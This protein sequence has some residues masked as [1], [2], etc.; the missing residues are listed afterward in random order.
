MADAVLVTGAFGLVGSATVKRLAADGRRVVATDLDIP[1]NRKAADK[2]PAGRRGALRRPHRPR[3]GRRADGRRRT[4]RHHPPG[5]DHPAVHLHA[6]RIWP[7]RSTSAARPSLIAAAEK[8]PSRPGS[9]SPPASRSTARATR[10]SMHRRADR[11]HPRQPGRRVRRAQGGGREAGPRIVAGLG[12]PAPRRRADR[13]DRL[14]H[15]ARQPLLRGSCC[16][17]TAGIQTVD[18]RDVARA[19]AAATTADAVGETLLIGG[20]DT[21]RLVRATS[22]PRWPPRWGWSAACPPA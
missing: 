12:D 14:V 7:R 5:R 15:E 13:R 2:L 18:V 16:R 20:D 6:S 3:R 4:E 8:Q 11:R 22:R 9:C 1:A 21:H 10:T 17:S 19:F